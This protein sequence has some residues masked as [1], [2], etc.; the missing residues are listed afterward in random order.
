MKNPLAAARRVAAFAARHR[1][2]VLFV[3]AIGF[4]ALAV[5]G[6]RGY[7][8]ERLAIE[9]ARLEPARTTA[10]VA[11]VV[12]R[13][14]LEAGAL[15]DPESMAVREIPAD[16]VPGSAVLPERFDE[17]AGARITQ[18]M[19]SGEPLLAQAIAG[20][21]DATFSSRIR[22]GIRAMSVLVDEVNSV[23]GMLQPGDR[24]DLLFTVRPPVG[25]GTPPAQEVTSTL[26]QDVA[27]LA[28]GRQLRAEAG[29]RGGMRHFT[30]ITVEVSPSQ[31][32][33]LIVAQRTGKLTAMLR[34]PDDRQP[35]PER[36]LDLNALLGIEPSPPG[37]VAPRPPGPE[38]IVGG[39]GALVSTAHAAGAEAQEERTAWRL[40]DFGREEEREAAAAR[41]EETQ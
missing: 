37:A 34:N 9:R 19:R 3:A 25:P 22:P 29:E 18:P 14:D 1:S 21:D 36:A 39:R 30:A 17:H 10:T 6:A 38:I 35:L 24:I 5:F 12:A 41:P 33:R 11:V 16:L 28:T 2:I 20:V 8:A 4:G 40:H 31:A 15:V 32:Q 13:R 27:V 26:L 7:L 23:S